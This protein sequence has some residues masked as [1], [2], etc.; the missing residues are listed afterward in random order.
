MST[1]KTRSTLLARVKNR[2]DASAWEEFY[3][4]YAP[5]LYRYARTQGLN[6]EAAEDIRDE[7]LA[8]VAKRMPEFRY[9]RERG[10]FK[11]WLRRIV[12]YRVIDRLRKRKEVQPDT[13][14]LSMAE[15]A[16]DAPDEV[17]DRVWR[18]QHLKHCVELVRDEVSYESYAAF[19][20]LLFDERPVE[21][22]C[23][24]LNM[25]ANQV[26]KAKSRVLQ[27]VRQRMAELGAESDE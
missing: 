20:M 21:E 3:S 25:N 24:K 15:A 19:C 16:D 5:L 17:W 22:V 1:D 2:S 18:Q 10:G 26:Y 4:L 14:L 9:Q 6:R 11:G 7:C 23:G 13:A 27:R 12:R 8:I